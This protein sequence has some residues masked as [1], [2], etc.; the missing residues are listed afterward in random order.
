MSKVS[1]PGGRRRLISVRKDF[2]ARARYQGCQYADVRARALEVHRTVREQHVG[3]AG[4]EAVN[5]FEIGAID[6]TWARTRAGLRIK[7]LDLNAIGPGSPR[8]AL[9]VSIRDEFSHLP[10]LRAAASLRNQDGIRGAVLDVG[11]PRGLSS[12][13]A[14]V[15]LGTHDPSEIRR[16][17]DQP[18]LCEGIADSLGGRV[19]DAGAEAVIL[20]HG[21]GSL[22]IRLRR[23]TLQNRQVREDGRLVGWVEPL[24]GK[25]ILVVQVLLLQVWQDKRPGT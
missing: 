18:E 12:R 21:S 5:L 7:A 20:E 22:P 11:D 9:A 6:G 25:A 13:I 4:V 15:A 16:G 24:H 1:V 19:I 2:A 3:A 17:I 8:A 10:A 14:M 23:R